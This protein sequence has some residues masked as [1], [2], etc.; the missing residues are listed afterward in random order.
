MKKVV[1]TT[2]IVAIAGGIATALFMPSCEPECEVEAKPS[3]IVRLVD[4]N[5]AG[6]TLTQVRAD[7]VW[8]EWTNEDG[9]TV[10]QQATCMD[11]ECTEWMLGTGAAGSYEYHAKVCGRQFDASVSVELND[12]GCEVD[13]QL[14]D[15]SVSTVDCPGLQAPESPELPTPPP[16][17]D[18]TMDDVLKWQIPS[19]PTCTLEARFSVVA[20]LYTERNGRMVPIGTN[21]AYF[22][23]DPHAGDPGEEIPAM[24][25]DQAC[26]RFGAGLELEGRIVVGAEACGQSVEAS[27][28]VGRTADGCHVETQFATLKFD[29]VA[30]QGDPI[31][32]P[33]P[34]K[35]ECPS[36]APA[37]S[38]YVFP[39]YQQ[40]DMLISKPTADLTYTVGE[41]F[42]GRGFCANEA[43]GGKC[44]LW[45][46]GWGRTGEFTA[47][48]EACGIESA[49]PF[50]VEPTADRCGPDTQYVLAFVDTRGCL[51]PASP[52]GHPP[53]TTPAAGNDVTQ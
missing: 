45:I 19:G 22:I 7:E 28:E 25:L 17:T 52:E 33:T 8:Y 6:A 21:R 31:Y 23:H 26:T 18:S 39:V 1:I 53:P 16:P 50:T 5:A 38:A 41:E 9:E 10:K 36:T 3:V 42:R 15:L 35:P 4:Q 44:A 2:G 47:F 51:L 46:T 27:F 43:A 24:C 20:S 14:V 12:G 37:P 13:T 49:I 30:C 40:G 29:A 34:P 32:E 11:D 48:T